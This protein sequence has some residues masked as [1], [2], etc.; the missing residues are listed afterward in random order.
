MN[1][2]PL[3]FISILK[4]RA[5][6]YNAEDKSDDL[7]TSPLDYVAVNRMGKTP[8]LTDYSTTRFSILTRPFMVPT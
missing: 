3:G 4:R 8:T 5:L 1:L 7:I 6:A 2:R